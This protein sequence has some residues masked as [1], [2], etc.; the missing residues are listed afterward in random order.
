V[1]ESEKPI[2]R[3]LTVDDLASIVEVDRSEE[4]RAVYRA[5]LSEDGSSLTLGR[6]AKDPPDMAPPW[7]EKGA[8]HRAGLWKPALEKGGAFWGAYTGGAFS[9]FALLGP[10]R[11]DGTAE[12]VALFVGQGFR[13]SGLGALL[14]ETVEAEARRRGIRALS[15]ASNPTESAVCFY[16]KSGFRVMGLTDK[17]L[18][19]AVS[20]D[21]L[22]A[23]PLSP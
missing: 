18:V 10:K 19:Q 15:A 9:G 22:M 11:N 21:V 14:L 12:L 1:T 20:G 5:E 23:K 3:V 7:G 4:I 2:L 6:Y 8:Q 13:R 17:S 16:R